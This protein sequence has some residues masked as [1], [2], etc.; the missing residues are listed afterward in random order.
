MM[1]LCTVNNMSTTMSEHDSNNSMKYGFDKI[2]CCYRYFRAVPRYQLEE[3]TFTA[4]EEMQLQESLN[5]LESG[6][7]HDYTIKEYLRHLDE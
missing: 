4:D 3:I 2:E 6:N 1:Y 7:F 5:N